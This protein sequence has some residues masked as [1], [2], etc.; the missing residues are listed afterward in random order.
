Q[1]VQRYVI[2][3]P[4]EFQRFLSPARVAGPAPRLP[5]FSKEIVVLISENETDRDVRI[6]VTGV[7][8]FGGSL[9]VRY[10]VTQGA[11]TS[12]KSKPMEAVIIE[13]GDANEVTLLQEPLGDGRGIRLPLR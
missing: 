3:T 9:M 8:R 12:H 10:R 7:E 2:R 1:W 4:E 13:R 11:K 6:A 5:D